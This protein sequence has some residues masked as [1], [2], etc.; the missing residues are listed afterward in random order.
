[1]YHVIFCVDGRLLDYGNTAVVNMYITMVEKNNDLVCTLSFSC[2]LTDERE[3]N[4]NIC[5]C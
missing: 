1:M 2:S 3:N 5:D 4:S